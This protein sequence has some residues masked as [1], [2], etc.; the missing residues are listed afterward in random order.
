[1]L[2]TSQ[3]GML[4][5]F[6]IFEFGIWSVVSVIFVEQLKFAKD[7]YS[8]KRL[9]VVFWTEL[10]SVGIVA[11]GAAFAQAAIPVIMNADFRSIDGVVLEYRENAGNIEDESEEIYLYKRMVIL[12]DGK[13][14]LLKEVC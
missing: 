3:S 13:E 8:R 14:R 7:G 2:Q 1:M 12:E 5:V 6:L 4:T 11:V 9:K 10:A